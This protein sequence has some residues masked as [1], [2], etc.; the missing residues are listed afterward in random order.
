MKKTA[1]FIAMLIL[2]VIS[3]ADQYTDAN[4]LEGLK[5]V[6]VVCDV[7]VCDPI[8]LLRRL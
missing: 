4:A 1:I 6:K 7:N 8:L 3:F 2:P 5:S